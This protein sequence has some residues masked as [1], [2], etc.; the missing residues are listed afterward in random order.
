MY[1]CMYEFPLHIY[2]I[3]L[4]HDSNSGQDIWFL[5]EAYW[6]KASSSSIYKNFKYTLFPS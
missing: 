5:L 2:N 3:Y 6:L 1:V 4:C